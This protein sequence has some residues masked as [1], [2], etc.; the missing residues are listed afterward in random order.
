MHIKKK[1]LA[2]LIRVKVMLLSSHG[3]L[4]QK[5]LKVITGQKMN[6][7]IDR[8]ILSYK[9]NNQSS[10]LINLWLLFTR[11]LLS[12][13]KMNLK[14]VWKLRTLSDHLMGFIKQLSL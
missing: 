9:S 3:I 5:M 14:G 8:E 13:M 2:M 7:L 10:S 4:S 11:I 1:M 12:K 6:P